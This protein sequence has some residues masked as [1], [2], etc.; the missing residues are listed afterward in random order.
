ML[1]YPL[2]ERLIDELLQTNATSTHMPNES[3]VDLTVTTD[4]GSTATRQSRKYILYQPGKSLLINTTGVINAN[5][6]GTDCKS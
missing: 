4:N 2:L 1:L 5:S 3:A 6:N